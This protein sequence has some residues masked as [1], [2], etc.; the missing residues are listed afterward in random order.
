M[1]PYVY[2]ILTLHLPKPSLDY[3]PEE[4]LATT[5]LQVIDMLLVVLNQLVQC[6]DIVI[7][8]LSLCWT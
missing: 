6:H 3:N 5:D 1:S 8:N 7:V 2:L 4:T